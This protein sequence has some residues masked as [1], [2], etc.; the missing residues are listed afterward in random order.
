MLKKNILLIFQNS[1]FKQKKNFFK[2]KKINSVGLI[3]TK[4]I[5]FKKYNHL[6]VQQRI[7]KDFGF[8]CIE[9]PFSSIDNI[10][11]LKLIKNFNVFVCS[12]K[13]KRN[14]INSMISSCA[15]LWVNIST[16]SSLQVRLNSCLCNRKLFN[17]ILQTIGGVFDI[18]PGGYKNNKDI[19]I[20]NNNLF[21]YL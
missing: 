15:S 10:L 1:G 8:L 5:F 13:Y 4:K 3:I 16:S 2:I 12:F 21:L 18:F 11:I 17:N 6:Y 14:F 9:E 20:K 7:A 19:G